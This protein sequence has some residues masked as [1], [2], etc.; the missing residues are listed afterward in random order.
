MKTILLSTMLLLS[1]CLG[2]SQ[3]RP[4]SASAPDHKVG[5]WVLRIDGIGPVRIGMSVSQLSRVLQEKFTIPNDE[6]SCSF[7]SASRHPQVLFM[8]EDGRV[9]RIDVVRRG[10][11]TE[12]GI[13]VGDSERKALR[14]YGKAL[15]VEEHAY[16]EEKGDHYLT[17]RS[18]TYGLRFGTIGGTVKGFHSGRYSSVQYI[19]GCL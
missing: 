12:R 17:L 2:L 18:G 4:N 1:S 13:Q 5:S 9:S 19:E 10:I 14:A 8:I 16:A 15:K 11:P 7:V 6:Q 3:Q